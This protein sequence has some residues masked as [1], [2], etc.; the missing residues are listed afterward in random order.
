MYQRSLIRGFGTD[1]VQSF[2]FSKVDEKNITIEKSF[3]RIGY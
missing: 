3:D 1:V 2:F